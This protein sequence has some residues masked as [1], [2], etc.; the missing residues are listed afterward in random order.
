MS[1]SATKSP[2]F[3]ASSE[4]ICRVCGHRAQSIGARYG[5]HSNREYDLARCDECGYAFVTDPTLDFANIYD[6][7]YY[8]GEGADPLVDYRFE[9]D[10]PQRTIRHYEWRGIAECVSALMGH[11]EGLR[12]LDYGC[13]NGGLVRYLRAEHAVEA[14]GFEEGSIAKA[15]TQ[16][17]IPLL[18]VQTLDRQHG[19]FD[20]VTAIEVLEHT[21]EPV[22]ELRRMSDMLRPGGLLFVTT[23]NAEPYAQR[24]Q[25]WSYVVPEIHISFFEPRT[26]ARAMADANLRPE[27]RPRSSG[28]NQI[29]KF[30]IMKNLR[31]R[32]R[33]ALTDAAPARLLGLVDRRVRLSAHPIGWR[34]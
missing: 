25:Q 5:R 12:W 30:K 17:G 34:I 7:R 32:K 20:V 4:T 22:A 3:T 6:D 18:D 14:F 11:T 24:L 15:A 1:P 13:G 8:A 26:L 9:L 2:G 29:L 33:N 23:G 10:H 19:T 16:R 27:H 28:F 31:I 21:F